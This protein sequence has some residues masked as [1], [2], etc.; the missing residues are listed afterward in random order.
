MS[1]PTANPARKTREAS[2][3]TEF[4]IAGVRTRDV[5]SV[6][7]NCHA[8]QNLLRIQH[9]GAY[10]R[11]SCRDQVHQ[12]DFLG[13]PGDRE[14]GFFGGEGDKVEIT[15]YVIGPGSIK[16]LGTGRSLIK[17]EDAWLQV[18]LMS[19]LLCTGRVSVGT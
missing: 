14:R 4:S 3:G 11:S 6:G 18:T 15:R 1:S 13:G 12:I 10:L 16:T 2:A 17:G 9:S 8:Q 19:I 5:T 7:S